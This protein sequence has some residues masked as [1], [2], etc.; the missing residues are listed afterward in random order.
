MAKLLTQRASFE[1]MDACLQ[2]YG[3]L[4]YMNEV[5]VERAVRDSRLGPIGGGTDE[6]MREILGRVLGLEQRLARDGREWVPAPA[7]HSAASFMHAGAAQQPCP[8][9]RPSL[10]SWRAPRPKPPHRRHA[11]PSTSLRC[12]HGL[13][14]RCSA[15]RSRLWRCCRHRPCIARRQTPTSRPPPVTSN[16]SGKRPSVSSTKNGKPMVSMGYSSTPSSERRS[17]SHRRHG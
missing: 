16:A 8:H 2:I 11:C 5:W 13:P 3:G 6:I 12:P 14:V 7:R 17:S 4:G 9:L 15:Q 10:S 1:L